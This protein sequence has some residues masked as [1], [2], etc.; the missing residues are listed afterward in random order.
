[1]KSERLV[2]GQN[3]RACRNGCHVEILSPR[4]ATPSGRAAVREEGRRG[5]G[6]L[7]V[8]GKQRGPAVGIEPR[9]AMPFRAP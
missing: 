5:S 6:F 8:S 3:L 1:M 4:L 9:E 2:D 7:R